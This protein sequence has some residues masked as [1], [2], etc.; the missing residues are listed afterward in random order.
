MATHRV[1]VSVVA[2][3]LAALPFG[4]GSHLGARPRVDPQQE[5][6]ALRAEM[7]LLRREFEATPTTRITPTPAVVEAPVFD[8]E[9]R[10]AIV[11]DVKR[12]LQA[13]MGLLPL[14]LI[15][16]RRH[17]FVELQSYDDKGNSNYGTAGYLGN[18]YFLTVKHGVVAMGQEG[19][20]DPRVMNSI[21][22][23]ISGRPIS[24]SVVDAGDAR[25]AVDSGDWAILEVKEDVDLPA[26]G[27]RSAVGGDIA[28]PIR[29]VLRHQANTRVVL[30][31]VV[32]HRP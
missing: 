1:H 5:V 18:G 24:A 19:A 2:A 20:F 29:D 13:E 16:D 25:V 32:G 12:Q 21:E 23:V 4:L 6:A 22:L 3:A 7:N 11:A 8:R 30:G 17:S 15:R 14:S 10:A 27:D 26:P 31:D 28:R 9:Q